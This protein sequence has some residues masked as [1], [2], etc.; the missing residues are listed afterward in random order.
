VCPPHAGSQGLI[1]MGV[2]PL[3][4]AGYVAAPEAGKDTRAILEAVAGDELDALVI[5]GADLLADFPDAALV[6]RALESEAFV[7]VVELL[8]T[9]TVSRAD[10][11]FPAAAYAE[12]EATFT[13]LERRL[14]KL[15]PLLTPPGSAREPWAVCAG[16]ATALGDDWGWGG[17]GDVWR[18]LRAEVPTH[19]ELDPAQ[20]TQPSPPAALNYES[21]YELHT[22]AHA[23]AGPGGNYPKGHRAGSPFQ[24]GQ[25]WP[26]SWEIRAFEAAQRPGVI[27]PAPESGAEAQASERAVPADQPPPGELVLYSGRLLYDAGSMVSHSRAL[28]ALARKPFVELAAEDAE[29]L[30]LSSGDEAVVSAKGLDLPLEVVV[31]DIA[32]GAVFVP[33]DQPGL[34]ANRLMSGPD[35]TVRV[36]KA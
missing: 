10:V 16:L 8:P 19:A 5:V 24:T 34:R 18:T 2:H 29:R 7:A 12:R 4:Q 9:E 3:L 13:N 6:E 20:L 28:A 36:A 35:P 17:F 26:L 31:A 27:P 30:G 25:S 33:Y 14:Q 1:D 23:L 15:E 22:G 21:G 32:P 11:V